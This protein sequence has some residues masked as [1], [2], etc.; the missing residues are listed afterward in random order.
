[1]ANYKSLR[2]DRAAETSVCPSEICVGE[3]ATGKE[4]PRHVITGVILGQ[5]EPKA[6]A[7]PK[8]LPSK[9]RAS[10]AIQTR[11]Q[12]KVWIEENFFFDWYQAT[13]ANSQG[14]G[15]CVVGSEEE[16][17][18]LAMLMSWADAVGL[19][20]A[21]PAPGP[22]GY[23][24]KVVLEKGVGGESVGSLLS[25][26]LGSAMPQILLSGAEG[27]CADL[28][29]RFRE[30]I[31]DHRVS[32]CDLAAD[33]SGAGLWDKLEVV[34][35]AFVQAQTDKAVQQH[36]MTGGA[37]KH[38][39][40]QRGKVSELRYAGDAVSGRTFYLG[41]RSSDA[42]IR[43]YEKGLERKARFIE[44]GDHEA[45]QKVDVSLV[46]IEVVL[47]GKKKSAAMATASIFELISSVGLVRRFVAAAAEV[48]EGFDM[49]KLG[50]V[51]IPEN[52]RGVRTLKDKVD[53]GIMQVG[54]NITRLAI[55]E[56]VK[57]KFDGDMSKAA[58]R[59]IEIESEIKRLF[60]ES[61]C[62]IG[63]IGRVMNEMQVASEQ[64]PERRAEVLATMAQDAAHRDLK[65]RQTA[66]STVVEAMLDL[67][68]LKAEEL[69]SLAGASVDPE[70]F[71]VREKA[72]I[73]A[74]A[75]RDKLSAAVMGE[76]LSMDARRLH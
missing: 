52:D 33:F 60:T 26:S 42:F 9:K 47:R 75:N 40:T 2:V 21:R 17:Q 74:I 32:R 56:L 57:R 49:G 44:R 70:G 54:R 39:K 8:G 16:K 11:E 65:A 22:M 34:A 4:D 48:I 58:L 31:T 15:T 20:L 68:L 18:G 41:S 66:A 73:E 71:A 55:S 6:E 59:P 67:E 19:S 72:T 37:D 43:V 1:M 29:P 53:H 46:R 63:V 24:S 69:A 25:G 27:T 23:R 28:A 45:A 50:K 12:M 62:D 61:L 30:V 36:E 35:K 13:I 7:A 76:H 5:M 64:T 14:Q 51:K 10:R 3:A 38:R